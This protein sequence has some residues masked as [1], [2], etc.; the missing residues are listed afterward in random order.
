MSKMLRRLLNKLI[1]NTK[2]NKYAIDELMPISYLLSLS[3]TR[4]LMLIRGWTKMVNNKGMFF[5]ARGVKIKCS[6]KL[7]IGR[8]VSFG[9]NSFIDA[10]SVNGVCLGNNVSVGKHTRI[11]ATGNIQQLG[12]GMNVGNNV[13]LGTDCFYGCAGGI[14]IGDD[15]IIGNLVT[16][17]SENHIVANI[18]IP[19]R[20]QGVKRKG[21]KVGNNCW[22]GAKST[23]LDG[24][25][26]EE[27]CIIAAGAVLNSGTYK[28]FGIY[29]GVPAK[30][31]KSRN[32]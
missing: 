26:I 5:V 32:E 23:I 20:L 27:G 18:E 11:E 8:G 17:H 19:I 24:V 2:G 7:I 1:S 12:I 28:A 22:I 14:E 21:I 25:T 31:L 15:T 6:S 29:G 3:M 30:L 10:L 4:T 9:N 13:G 16:F